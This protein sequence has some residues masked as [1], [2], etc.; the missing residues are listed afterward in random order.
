MVFMSIGQGVLGVCRVIELR[1]GILS[2]ARRDLYGVC[3]IAAFTRNCELGVFADGLYKHR[4]S[5]PGICRVIEPRAGIF[6]FW[7]AAATMPSRLLRG[8][9]RSELCQ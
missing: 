5:V 3:G 6:E 1:V 4:A 7:A 9:T 2:F 8:I